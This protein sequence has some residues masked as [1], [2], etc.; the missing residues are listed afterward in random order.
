MNRDAGPL[1]MVV[2]TV[3]LLALLGARSSTAVGADPVRLPDGT[4]LAVIDFD[5]HV[6]G[7][8]GRLGCNTGACHGSFQG[9]GGFQLSLFGH[10]PARDYRSLTRDA[11]GRRVAPL[12]PDRSLLLLKAAGQVP[13]EGGQRFAMASWEYRVI[14]AWIAGG[15]RRDDRA[16]PAEAIEIRPDAVAFAKAGETAGL[17]VVARF[18]DGTQAD[19]TPFCDLRAKD[20]AVA[21]V[22]PGG[23]VRG[24]RSGE[25]AL[26]ASYRGLLA[27]TPVTVPTGRIVAIPEAPGSG[28]IDREVDAR[29]RA[30]G[31]E[32]S[33]PSSDAEFLRRVMLDVIG[34][35]PSPEEVRAFLDDRSPD[36]RSRM[37]DALLAHPMHAALWATRYL[38]ITGCDSDSMEKPDDLRPRRASMWHGWFRKRFAENRPYDEIARGMLCATSRD[39]QDVETWVRGEASRMLA[40][41][42]GLETDY[43]SK[44]GLDLFWRRYANEEYFPIEQ[45]AERTAVAMM[46]V[47]LECAQCHKHPFDRWTQ[48]DYR[49][50]ANVFAKVQFGHSRSGLAATARLLQERR[51]SDPGGH[52]API[53]RLQEIYVADRPA[54]QLADPSTGQPL[55]PRALGGPGITEAGDPRDQLFAWLK[56][57]D[58]PYFAPSFVNRVW[59]A[60]FGVGLVDPVDGFSVANPP[61][62]ARL[63]DALSADFVEHGFDIRRLERMILGSRAYQRSSV[64]PEGATDDRAYLAHSSPRP[65]MAEV[66]VD[67]LNDA[68]GV[69]G[70]FGD[71]APPGS[72]A[73]EVAANKVTTPEL[74]RVFRIFGRPQRIATCD[75]ERP[76]QPAVSQALFLMTDAALQDKIR[77]GRLRALL[78]SD[79]C[80]AEII[81][82]L[83]L[84]TLS[85]LPTSDELDAGLEHLRDASDRAGAMADIVW[86]LINT[87]EFAL[88]H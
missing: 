45:M 12:D 67:V 81:E 29:L 71:D 79:R 43:A 25:T 23:R 80:D 73:I 41:R 84:A 86:A 16:S 40:A 7:L 46:G 56:R 48:A 11:M 82:E 62:N 18:A 76:K 65:L 74:A 54:R 34:S 68:L 63:L 6:A 51:R 32:P 14:R 83:V 15:A 37:I 28:L 27:S 38:D 57:P 19:V 52:L 30:L 8:F 1:R 55:S 85:R 50:Y 44:P 5:R 13:H 72:R 35:L 10:D 3:G 22:L 53:P 31:I 69:T 78:E 87:R 2:G 49:S 21:G 75:C 33:G 60:Y 58:N 9:R 61:S 24:L 59:A 70:D 17:S 88:N 26:I 64:P 42:A 20:D 77:K 4:E 66:L 47:R 36:K 39:G